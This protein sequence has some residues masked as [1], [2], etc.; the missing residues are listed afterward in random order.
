M[1]CLSK[2]NSGA[3]DEAYAPE[4][5][6]DEVRLVL[7]GTT[8]ALRIVILPAAEHLGDAQHAQATADGEGHP[9]DPSLDRVHV[10][11]P[12]D[13]I[14]QSLPEGIAA[15]GLRLPVVVLL[16]QL[17]AQPG[18]RGDERGRAL[19]LFRIA[20]SRESGLDHHHIVDR[21]QH[22]SA[23]H[24][25]ER[26]GGE[27]AHALHDQGAAVAV[28][29]RI[30]GALHEFVQGKA[31]ERGEHQQ[32]DEA[33]HLTREA[34]HGCQG[35]EHGQAGD[36][37]IDHGRAVPPAMIGLEGLPSAE[38]AEDAPDPRRQCVECEAASANRVPDRV[39]E[40][41]CDDR[42]SHG[43]RGADEQR[44][45]AEPCPEEERNHHLQDE[46]QATSHGDAE[47]HHDGGSQGNTQPLE[48]ASPPRR[49][50]PLVAAG[51]LATQPEPRFVVHLVVEPVED[52]DLGASEA[53]Q[54]LLALVGNGRG[55][56]GETAIVEVDDLVAEIVVG[57]THGAIVQHQ[58]T[59]TPDLARAAT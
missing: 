49:E 25:H 12:A 50:L 15:D 29:E 44:C 4:R 38:A 37:E 36:A 23:E 59:P 52:S 28:L 57:F 48:D 5:F 31:R 43:D 20:R 32:T 45:R 40:Q 51:E 26:Q 19:A 47:R 1:S 16:E 30:A 35:G 21:Q 18:M 3:Y 46:H 10:H 41:G 24:R 58:L 34:F 13:V 55:D 27:S 54:S 17:T 14:D 39:D 11:R 8:S 2:K 56:R 7:F 22:T 42:R 33:A 53:A 6:F 9:Q